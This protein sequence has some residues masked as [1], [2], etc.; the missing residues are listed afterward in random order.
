[1]PNPAMNPNNYLVAMLDTYCQWLNLWM[2]TDKT[3]THRYEPMQFVTFD[4]E[5]NL[6]G[7]AIVHAFVACGESAAAQRFLVQAAITDGDEGGATELT[8]WFEIDTIAGTNALVAMVQGFDTSLQFI[9]NEG[10]FVN[11]PH[12]WVKEG[13]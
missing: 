13:E 1:M 2:E 5:V 8:A 4:P 7:N 10:E 6:Y 11:A 12:S 3:T 9:Y